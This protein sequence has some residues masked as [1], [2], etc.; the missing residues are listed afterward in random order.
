M[1]SSPRL[2]QHLRAQRLP[3]RSSGNLELRMMSWVKLNARLNDVI[4]G[5]VVALL[6]A[7]SEIR[8]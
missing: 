6:A 2:R 1:T 7:R 4:A 8:R 3:G 5:I